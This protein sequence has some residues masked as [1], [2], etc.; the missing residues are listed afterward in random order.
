[1]ALSKEE[2]LRQNS[3]KLGTPEPPNNELALIRASKLGDI[4]AFEELVNRY[5]SK[6]FR[7]AQ[8]LMN[9]REDAEAAVQEAFLTAF[10]RLEHLRETSKF[11]T[12]LI[13]ITLNQWLIKLPKKRLTGTISKDSHSDEDNFPM[14]VPDWIQNPEELYSTTELREILC[15]CLHE[16]AP[17]LKVVFVLRDVE[18]LSLE[19]VAGALGLSLSRVKAQ[20]LRARL[21]LRELLSSYFNDTERSAGVE[22]RS[23]HA[24]SIDAEQYRQSE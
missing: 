13:R 17:D 19:E 6:L 7:I 15:E 24:E 14:E 22:P 1:M 12:W 11:A 9:N 23:K 16:L 4:V 20:S 21:Q 3:P 18:G 8:H 5:D 2:S 10:Q